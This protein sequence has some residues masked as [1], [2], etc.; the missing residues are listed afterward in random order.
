M[1]KL[2]YQ[3]LNFWF[4]VGF[5]AAIVSLSIYLLLPPLP[6]FYNAI[7]WVMPCLMLIYIAFPS[8]YFQNEGNLTVFTGSCFTMLLLSLFWLYDV[9]PFWTEALF[10]L[11]IMWM[12][13]L[14]LFR[15]FGL[16]VLA[17]I[18]FG[19]IIYFC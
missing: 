4:F 6:K 11:Y 3:Q 7:Y 5:V 9:R 1:K 18:A 14:S 15:R 12:S 10:L 2:N 8:K 19:Y 16:F 17:I 13:L